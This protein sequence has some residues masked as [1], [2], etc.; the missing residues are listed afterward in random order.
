MRKRILA[1]AL[2][3]VM[4][5][6]MLSVFASARVAGAD[7]RLSFSGTTVL[8]FA[9]VTGGQPTDTVKISLTLR[10]NGTPVA[11]WNGSGTGSASLSKTYAGKSGASYTLVLNYSINGVAQPAAT[12]TQT[13][14]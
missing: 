9:N 13:C 12:V 8:C 1:G 6:A 2:L 14:P 11:G 4:L 7:P 5:A 10:E 3:F